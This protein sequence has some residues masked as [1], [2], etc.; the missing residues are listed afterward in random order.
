MIFEKP[1]NLKF[2]RGWP[3]VAGVADDGCGIVD[4]DNLTRFHKKIIFV[5]FLKKFILEENH[6][7]FF[8]TAR[9]EMK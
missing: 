1:K 3:K 2:G 6:A 5:M 7:L 4:L 9:Y 8:E